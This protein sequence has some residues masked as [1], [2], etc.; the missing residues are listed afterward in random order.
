M[1]SSRISV[2]N[3]AGILAPIC[4]TV[5]V[6]LGG[7]LTPGYSH[8]R[9]PIS[10]LTQ[11]GAVGIAS[12]HALFFAY[13]LLMMVF[14][15]GFWLRMRKTGRKMAAGGFLLLLAVGLAGVLMFWFTQD[16]IGAPL[17]FRGL[18]HLVLAGVEAFGTMAGCILCGLGIR[19]VPG[20]ST[21][22]TF[23]IVSALVIF[24]SGGANVA[25]IGINPY[26]GLVERL[27]IFTF[28]IWMFVMAS[29]FSAA[30]TPRRT[31]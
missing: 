3:I 7:A 29:C 16:P 11:T 23:S 9:H 26:F 22:S 13:N 1:T 6:L 14:S 18:G 20:C 27:T 4:Y 19:N 24:V 12:V 28:L 31:V 21:L 2:W 8:L 5:A 17:T 10:S 15:A 30:P 25:T